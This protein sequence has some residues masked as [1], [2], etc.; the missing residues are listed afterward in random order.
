MKKIILIL[1]VLFS[2]GAYA[3]VGIGNTDP[4]GA[5][6]VESTDSG[7]VIPRVFLFQ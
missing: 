2:F 6:D 1:A 4:Q 5:L 7:L 3:Q